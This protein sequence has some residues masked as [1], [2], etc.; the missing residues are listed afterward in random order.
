MTTSSY[1]Q[2]T[3]LRAGGEGGDEKRQQVKSGN[4]QR[5]YG[6]KEGG[7]LPWR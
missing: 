1:S 6:I 3:G 7:G 5:L 4:F 2:A